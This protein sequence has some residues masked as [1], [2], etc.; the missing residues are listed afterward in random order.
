MLVYKVLD[1]FFIYFHLLLTLFNTLGWAWKKT[2]KIHLLTAG[3][4]G[5]SWVF[6]GIW[7]G[8]GY[9]PLTHWHWLVREK[10]GLV[11]MPASYIEFMIEYFTPWDVDSQMVDGW[12]GG[13]FTLALALSLILNYH[14]WRKPRLQSEKSSS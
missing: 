6:L 14:D 8:L 5:F 3:L 11:D 10:L 4:T 7:F 9:C 2:R 1:Q 13:V 12:V